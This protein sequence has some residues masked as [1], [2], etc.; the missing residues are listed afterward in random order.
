MAATAGGTAAWQHLT[1]PPAGVLSDARLQL[2]HAVQLIVSAPISY[3]PAR[4]D[5]SHTNLEWRPA[6]GALVTNPLTS[7]GLRLGLRPRDLCLLATGVDVVVRPVFALDGH[8]AAD[9]LAWMRG[10]LSGDG[11]DAARLTTE[12]HYE[13]PPHAVSTGRAYALDREGAF[14]TLASAYQDA[15]LVTSEV[16]ARDAEAS[17]PRCW[18][19]HFDLATLI[20]LAPSAD[21]SP[22]TI[23]VGMSPGDDSYP[24]PYFYVGPYPYPSADA[25]PRLGA[26]HWHT[27]G[28]I[29]AVL[30]LGDL[31]V[32][33]DAAGQ[34]ALATAF[35]EA[36]VAACRQVLG[37]R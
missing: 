37:V 4:A 14:E 13:I 15:W 2:H 19:H 21:G 36:T 29:G 16:V 8:T 23:G 7:G 27:K 20:T 3:L 26:G 18:P 24:E 35:V 6:S 11:L 34:A 17:P 1:S 30:T 28:W 9:A 5:D 12:K 31:V 10:V 33:D 25:L 32:H 22:R